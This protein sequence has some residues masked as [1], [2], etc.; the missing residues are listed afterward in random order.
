MDTAASAEAVSQ[1][2]N[3]TDKPVQNQLS[4]KKSNKGWLIFTLP[5][6]PEALIDLISDIVFFYRQDSG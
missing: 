3:A 5:P 1:D 4:L 2:V 6:Y